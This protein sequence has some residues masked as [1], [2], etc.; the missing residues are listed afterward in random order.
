MSMTPLNLDS[1]AYKARMRPVLIA[2]FPAVIALLVWTESAFAI[3]SW[4]G[5]FIL[6]VGLPYALGEK[7]ADAG[8]M[9]QDAL[10]QRWGGSPTL[11]LLRHRTS[12]LNPITFRQVHAA[13]SVITGERMPT[14][15]EEATDA[16]QA[17]VI[18][19]RCEER[20]RVTAR[21]RPD[22]YRSVFRANAEYGFRRNLW[23]IRR[24]AWLAVAIALVTS[25]AHIL[26]RGPTGLVLL[27]VIGA[28][29]IASY[30]RGVNEGW[31]R[32]GAE[33]YAQRL[34]ENCEQMGDAVKTTRDAGSL[35]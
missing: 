26:L 31:V 33:L 14:A 4:L 9:A 22:E 13:L 24:Y 30:L 6:I 7:A 2:S 5:S 25:G 34:I 11:R 32:E 3:W 27:A 20:L 12:P 19:Q 18:Y 35:T 21:E 28:V 16:S 29:S 23:A 1:Y 17:E 15:D 8:R 10:W